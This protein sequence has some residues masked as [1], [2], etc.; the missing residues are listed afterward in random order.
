M[1]RSMG[2]YLAPRAAAFEHRIKA[3]IADG[4]VYDFHAVVAGRQMSP[5]IEAM[6]RMW[7]CACDLHLTKDSSGNGTVAPLA[8]TL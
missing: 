4:G 5:G 1:R 2:G 7:R 6:L 3:L 8:V